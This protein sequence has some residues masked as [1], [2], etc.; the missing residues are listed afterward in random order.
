ME[1][2][3]FHHLG[4]WL[5]NPHPLFHLGVLLLCGYAGGKVANYLRAP[6]VSGYIV[7]GMLL[8]PSILGVFNE[9]VVQEQLTLITDIALSIIA[10]SIGGTLAL[11]KMRRLGRQ[12]LW[13]TLIQALA[14]FALTTLVIGTIF[15]LL[16][17]WSPRA[18][19]SLTGMFLPLALVIG[20]ISAATAPA[21]TLAI[22][23]EY[24][25]RGPLTTILLGVVALDD[26][27]TIFF[28][29]FTISLAK[30]MITPG[31]LSWH[32]MVLSPVLHVL[33]AMVLGGGIGLCLRGL[34]RF[35]PR[36]TG[37]LVVAVG[38]VFLTAGLAIG[39]EASSLLANMMLGFIVVNFVRH[40]HDVFAVVEN[41]EEPIFAML[42]TLAG[43]HLDLTVIQTA[44]WL[45]LLITLGRFAGKLAGSHLGAR[46]SHAPPE[47][48]KYLG[49]GLLPTAGV[50]VGLVLLAKNVFGT[51]PFAEVMVSGVLGSVI[52]NELLAPFLVRYGLVKAGEVRRT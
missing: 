39:L 43:A 51:F 32:S 10:F 41:V 5:E 33:S 44:G 14:A 26:G 42:F 29:A 34:I 6:R 30:A 13:I 21:A 15:P 31:S 50:T 27:V 17:G 4:A 35:V 9:Q 48:R 12:I 52:I 37:M 3:S 38:S 22:V 11:R 23:H 24:K 47:V 2:F 49:L 18:S 8:S 36:R 45:A 28:Y 7:T 40:S 20:A 46:I 1:A 16:Y 19:D 25:A